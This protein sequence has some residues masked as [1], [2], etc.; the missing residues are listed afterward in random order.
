MSADKTNASGN[1]SDFEK[2]AMMERAR[3]LKAEQKASKKR[4]LGEAALQE[5]IAAMPPS[6][7]EIAERIHKIVCETTPELWPKTWYG[8]PAY[9]NEEGKVVF[10]F[11]GAE[12]FESRYATFGFNDTAQLDDGNVWPTAYA[13]KKLS[14]N[15][16]KMIA[17]LLKKA[18]GKT[19]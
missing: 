9:A 16:E 13:I 19:D 15:E 8:M 2:K 17:K 18:V 11:Q 6:D 12:K 14:D 4:E 3:E 5:A 10:F 7:R 1:F